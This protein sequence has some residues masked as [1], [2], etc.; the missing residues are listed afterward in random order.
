MTYSTLFEDPGMLRV[1][2]TNHGRICSREELCTAE[3]AFG[4]EYVLD[5]IP[6]EWAGYTVE[7]DTFRLS[8]QW[9]IDVDNISHFLRSMARAHTHNKTFREVSVYI[10]DDEEAEEKKIGTFNY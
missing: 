7:D 10:V 1:I 6:A 8:A 5:G 9:L 3:R 4:E 2:M